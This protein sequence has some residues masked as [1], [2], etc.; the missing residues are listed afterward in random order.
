MGQVWQ[1]TDTQLACSVRGTQR[2][3]ASELLPVQP[4]STLDPYE[5]HAP[6]AR[7][8]WVRCIEVYQ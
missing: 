6:S 8:G 4:G 7:A 2:A 3:G 5:I 1:A